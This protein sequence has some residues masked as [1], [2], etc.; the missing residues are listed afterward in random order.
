MQ[1]KLLGGINKIP[2]HSRIK[3]AGISNFR[4]IMFWSHTLKVINV[5]VHNIVVP[6]ETDIN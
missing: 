2:T 3:D 1:F 4:N 6:I 5:R